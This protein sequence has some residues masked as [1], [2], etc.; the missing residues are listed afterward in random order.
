M[1]DMINEITPTI[2]DKK[3][4]LYAALILWFGC[5]KLAIKTSKQFTL[6]ISHDNSFVFESIS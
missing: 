4:N 5:F 3:P 6:F 2:K 1:I